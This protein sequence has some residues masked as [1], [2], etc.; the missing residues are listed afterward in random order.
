M[1][2]FKLPGGINGTRNLQKSKEIKI[3]KFYLFEE[4]R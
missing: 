2:Y 1:P 4:M 3:L